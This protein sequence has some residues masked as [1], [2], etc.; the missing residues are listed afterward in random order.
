MSL[1]IPEPDFALSCHA[2][3][4]K[5]AF[6]VPP[7]PQATATSLDAFG[8]GEGAW[9]KAMSDE[10]RLWILMF[11]PPKPEGGGVSVFLDPAGDGEAYF[12]INVGEDRRPIFRAARRSRSG[13]KVDSRWNCDGFAELMPP[14]G[15]KPDGGMGGGIG[16]SIPFASL[17]SI[18]PGEG[19]KVAFGQAGTA[20]RPPRLW[21]PLHFSIESPGK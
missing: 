14:G 16:F 17:G 10:E 9:A 5:R 6:A 20:F 12:E 13:T 19:W 1:P 18:K 3:L 21:V 4:V 2:C 7:W 15:E 11:L 8:L